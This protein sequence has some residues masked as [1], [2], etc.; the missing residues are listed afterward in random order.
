MQPITSRI[1]IGS[2]TPD[3]P[4]R[5]RA[6][7]RRSVD[8]RSTANTAA[9]SVAA[10][11]EPSSS[12][13]SGSRSRISAA[14]T[15]VSAAVAS[16]PTVASAIDV[17]TTGRISS[18]PLE[19]PPS[20]RISATATMPAWRATSK[21]LKLIHPRPSEPIAMPSPSTS[22]RPGIRSRP[23][24]SEATS[25]AASRTPTISTSWPSCTPATLPD[26]RPMRILGVLHPGGGRSGLLAERAAATGDELVEW[27]PARGEPL[28]ATLDA[29]GALVVFGGGMNVRDAERMPWLTGEIELL[30]DAVSSGVPTLGVCLGGQLLAV[31]AG[32][33]VRR[34][35]EPEI[36]FFD[37][38]RTQEDPV[39]GALPQ[40]FEAYQWHSYTFELPAGAV[41][42]ARS[43]VCSQA[44]RLRD[45]A[46][47]VQFHPEVTPDIVREWA[48]DFESDPDAVAMG[49]DPDAHLAWVERRLPGVD[50]ARAAAVRRL[51]GYSA[52][53]CCARRRRRLDQLRPFN[54]RAVDRR[55]GRGHG[56]AGVRQRREQLGI[57]GARQ[58]RRLLVGPGQDHRH[59]VVHRRGDRVGARGDDRGRG[60]QLGADAPPAPQPGERERRTAVDRVAERDPVALLVL[61]LQPLVPAVGQD[62]AAPLRTGVELGERRLGGDG[63]RAA[64]DR[65]EALQLAR[66]RRHQPPAQ[67]V[68]RSAVPPPAGRPPRS[69]P[70]GTR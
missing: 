14:A 67:R 46:W 38:A 8:P 69:P 10:T 49:F 25:P 64:V 43:P 5:V 53:C 41:E 37:V 50:G 54:A 11:V 60:D 48:L 61:G 44:F 51:P 34:A 35:S 63:L 68:H 26:W 15:A 22:T 59:P 29:F 9:A 32:A 7:R 40:R 30:R 39:L 23:A 66:P 56:H 21:S 6:R 2:L 47:G 31:A 18:K 4:S 33:E 58:P 55:V 65:R 45:S 12:A 36:G 13:G 16:V 24:A 70:S 52:S 28:P 20:N 27:V 62:Q 3:S 1:A 17:Q 57:V 19:S 42:L